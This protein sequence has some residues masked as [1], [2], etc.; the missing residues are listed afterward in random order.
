[1]FQQGRLAWNWIG[2]LLTCFNEARWRKLDVGCA[3][4]AD[5]MLNHQREVGDD[6]V[7]DEDVG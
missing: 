1:M 5:W 7:I 6:A 4:S 2:A 3:A